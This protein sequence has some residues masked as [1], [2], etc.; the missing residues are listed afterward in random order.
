MQKDIKESCLRDYVE[1]VDT[2]VQEMEKANDFGDVKKIYKLV[3]KLSRKP[4]PPPSNLTKDEQGNLLK[5]PQ[6][7]VDRWERFLSKKFSATEAEADRPPLDPLPETKTEKDALQR[8]EFEDA[9]K[10]LSN[11][12][13]TGPDD[14]PIDVYK[15]C[16]RLNEELYQFRN[17]CGTTKRFQTIWESQNL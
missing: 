16:P 9:L 3:N 17:L 1:W 2:C 7:V 14:I 11:A 12:K 4:K 5:S 6:E 13:A 10:R 15:K 8:K